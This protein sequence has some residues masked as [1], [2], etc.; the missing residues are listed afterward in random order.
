MRPLSPR[1]NDARAVHSGTCTRVIPRMRH[2]LDV[3]SVCAGQASNK[4]NW[5]HCQAPCGEV[6]IKIEGN[7]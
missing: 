4:Y 7:P 3:L 5:P 1:G 6:R 2:E